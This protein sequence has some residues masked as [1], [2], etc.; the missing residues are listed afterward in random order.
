MITAILVLTSDVDS[1]FIIDPEE[2]DMLKMHLMAIDGVDFS[3][4]NF[5]KALKRSWYDPDRIPW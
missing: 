1:D 5:K 4:E 3:E 2:I